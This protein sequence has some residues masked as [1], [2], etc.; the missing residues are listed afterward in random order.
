MKPLI[1]GQAPSRL[2]DPREPLS[3]RSG[4]RLAALC[5]LSLDAFVV[6]FERV[7]LLDYFPG[8]A[9]KGDLFP[10]EVARFSA[11][12]MTPKLRQRRTVLLGGKVAAAF[13]L[14][15]RPLLEWFEEVGDG[16]LV[17]VAPH[18]SGVSSWWNEPTNVVAARR[19]WRAFAKEA[20]R[21]PARLRR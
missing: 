3:G 6:L 9:G 12:A 8:K 17:A 14:H 7:N 10:H 1:V 21:G 2:S 4:A 15:R 19:F 11:C 13:H 20:E 16:A 18:P 5:G